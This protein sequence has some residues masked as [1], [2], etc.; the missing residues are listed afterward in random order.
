MHQRGTTLTTTIIAS[1]FIETITW[2]ATTVRA[3][4]HPRPGKNAPSPSLHRLWPGYKHTH[5]N[6][7]EQHFKPCADRTIGK[8]PRGDSGYR[9][10][11]VHVCIDWALSIA[12]ANTRP[13]S[14]L[15]T[16]TANPPQKPVATHLQPRPVP[17]LGDNHNIIAPKAAAKKP[18]QAIS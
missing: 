4:R 5:Q 9:H 10:Y 15:T 14:A 6:Y 8:Q 7:A 2:L 11:D 12:D 13:D 1:A 17:C 16:V 18:T 3:K